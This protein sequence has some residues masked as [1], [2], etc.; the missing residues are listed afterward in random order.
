[1][2]VTRLTRRVLAP[3][4]ALPLFAAAAA[5]Q[6]QVT[7]GPSQRLPAGQQ[8]TH[9]AGGVRNVSPLNFWVADGD[10]ATEDHLLKWNDATG[11]KAV[12]PL[13]STT[14]KTYGW[15][16]DFERINGVVYGIE[17]FAKKLYTL[18]PATGICTD[19]GPALSYSRLFGLAYDASGDVLYAVDQSSRKLLT[20][21]RSTGVAT[22]VLTFAS[23]FSDIRGL[24]FNGADRKVYFCDDA[25]ETIQRVDLSTKVV[26][27]VMDLNDGPN[28]KVDEIDFFAGKLFAS[29]RTYDAATDVWSMQL[30]LL[31]LDDALAIPYGP[32]IQDC[33]AHSLLIQSVPETVHWEQVAGPLPA[34]L[35]DPGNLATAVRFDGPGRYVF[36]LR[37][38]RFSLVRA[39]DQV[40]IVVEQG[41]IQPPGGTPPRTTR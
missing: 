6:V 40:T 39:T 3:L 1:M 30:A 8:M 27:H 12:G 24:A 19:V 17:T 18:D 10:A 11:L 2:V 25:T 7:A 14:G 37:A 16:S 33:S 9:L 29:Y 15:P 32:V 26:E 38:Q 36:E 13:K 35:I 31:D 21:N 5:A 41:P 34:H 20:L 4:L 28:A 22:V 23:Q